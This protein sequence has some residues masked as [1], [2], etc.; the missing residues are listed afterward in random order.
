MPLYFAGD[1]YDPDLGSCLAGE[2]KRDS[3]DP[4]LQAFFNCVAIHNIL[5]GSTKDGHHEGI[6]VLVPSTS[7]SA[8]AEILSNGLPTEMRVLEGILDGVEAFMSGRYIVPKVPGGGDPWLQFEFDKAGPKKEQSI[9][10]TLFLKRMELVLGQ[11][12]KTVKDCRNAC[13]DDDGDLYTTDE[14]RKKSQL[15]NAL[16][17]FADS[18]QK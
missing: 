3:K 17:G 10:T 1:I 5:E 15:M 7:S 12:F 18:R 6:R 14:L 13:S 8:I 11:E 9:P 2:F 4:M 16:Y